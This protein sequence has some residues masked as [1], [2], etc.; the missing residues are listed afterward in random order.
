MPLPLPPM[1]IPSLHPSP[2]LPLPPPPPPPLILH[3]SQSLLTLHDHAWVPPAFLEGGMQYRGRGCH[4][5]AKYNYRGRWGEVGG[6]GVLVL[7]TVSRFNQ[8]QFIVCMHAFNAFFAHVPYVNVYVLHEGCTS[9]FW[10]NAVVQK[11]I[12][13]I[14]FVNN[15]RSAAKASVE[16]SMTFHPIHLYAT[17][18][19][20]TRLLYYTSE[21]ACLYCKR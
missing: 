1:L 3:W 12:S 2:S 21:F 10:F 17:Y 6:G 13:R 14:H 15:P 8:C 16:S 18:M 9:L 5:T 19:N 4:L 7:S 20:T 11:S